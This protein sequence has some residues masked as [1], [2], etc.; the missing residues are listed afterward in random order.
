MV[1]R[2]RNP[3]PHRGVARPEPVREEEPVVQAAAPVS[4]REAPREEDPRSRAAKRAAE[5][6]STIDPNH[7]ENDEF[8]IDPITI[9][10]GWT[11]EWKTFSVLG[12]ENASAMLNYRRAGWEE[13]PMRRHPEMMPLGSSEQ[14]IFRKGMVLME[15]PKVISD[16]FE[17]R[18][19]RRAKQQVLDKEAE[20]KG[21][22]YAN[23]DAGFEAR[24]NKI[25][26]KF[27]AGMA[28]PDA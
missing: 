25:S 23:P 6:R 11:Y 17:D 24:G 4:Y 19:K 15:R 18:M 1:G 12:Q 22:A 13:V 27:E 14:F 16:D 10:D 5:L 9:P 8:W 26:R 2:P 3:A 7:D 21:G 28:V 20:A